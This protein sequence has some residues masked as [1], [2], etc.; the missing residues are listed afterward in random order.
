MLRSPT[1]KTQ[2]TNRKNDI[3]LPH[4]A[5][6]S[7]AASVGASQ[8]LAERSPLETRTAARATYF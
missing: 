2:E 1:K 5:L 7:A 6:V 3:A 4:G 8:P